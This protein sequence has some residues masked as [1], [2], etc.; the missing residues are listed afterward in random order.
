MVANGKYRFLRLVRRR[1]LIGIG[2]LRSRW[3][4]TRENNPDNPDIP[5]GSACAP[6]AP[7]MSGKTGMFWPDPRKCGCPCRRCSIRLLSYDLYRVGVILKLGRLQSAATRNLE[8]R[9]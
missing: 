2:K 3:V 4:A 5:G 6:L 1:R 8:Q 9:S 7:G